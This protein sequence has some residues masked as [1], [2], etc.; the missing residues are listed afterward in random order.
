MKRVLENRKGPNRV[1]LS[2]DTFPP[3]LPIK[4]NYT[5]WNDMVQHNQA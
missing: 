2:P 1:Q 3:Q 4:A 5:L